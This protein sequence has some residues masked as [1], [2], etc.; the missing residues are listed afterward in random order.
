MIGL[1]LKRNPKQKIK[2]KTKQKQTENRYN[3]NVYHKKYDLKMSE[4]TIKDFEVLQ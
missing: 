1:L 2:I 3:K 4:N